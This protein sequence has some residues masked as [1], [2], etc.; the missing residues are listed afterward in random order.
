MESSFKK[1]KALVFGATG[2]TG[3]FVTELLS[4]DS[5]FNEV[6]AFVRNKTN[7]NDRVNQV[8]FNADNLSAVHSKIKG[9]YLF[10]CLGTTIKQAG[11]KE[12]FRKVDLYLVEEIAKAARE[13]M[14]GTF[15]VVSSVG[16]SATSGNF[17]LR[18]K[19]Q[20]EESVKQ[21]EFDN[22]LIMRPSMLLGIRPQTR[23]LEDAGKVLIKLMSPLMIGKLKKYKPV[24][25]ADLARFM[26][27]TALT[28]NGTHIYES[29][30]I[31]NG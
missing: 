8:E 9:D 6:V 2:L 21:L 24:H 17:Y 16:A 18:T 20:M 19:G 23:F 22:L 15:S 5:R 31:L 3:R 10:C 30:T 27:E 1:N 26:I 4:N 14:V 7:F 13:N 29:D 11:S 12:N 25:A 28:V